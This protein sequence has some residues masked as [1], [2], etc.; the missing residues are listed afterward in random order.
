MAGLWVCLKISADEKKSSQPVTET[1]VNLF[2][3]SYLLP[4]RAPCSGCFLVGT[5]LHRLKR[6]RLEASTLKTSPAIQLKPEW[7]SRQWTA[8]RLRKEHVIPPVPHNFMFLRGSEWHS[9]LELLFLR[10]VSFLLRNS[11]D[12]P[13]CRHAPAVHLRSGATECMPYIIFFSYFLRVL[14]ASLLSLQTDVFLVILLG[15]SA[16]AIHEASKAASS[17][18]EQIC[19]RLGSYFYLPDLHPCARC[20]AAFSYA[21]TPH[22]QETHINLH[23]RDW[24]KKRSLSVLCSVL[25]NSFT[26]TAEMNLD[27]CRLSTQVTCVICSCSQTSVTS[28]LKNWPRTKKSNMLDIWSHFLVF[29][30]DLQ[31]SS[32]LIVY[33]WKLTTAHL[34]F[35]WEPP[36]K[37][38]KQL[39]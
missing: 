38:P 3:S 35:C 8:S 14:P 39:M 27:I 2:S 21:F 34:A 4:P 32:R 30:F 1:R 7:A 10:A 6:C 5:G 12:T 37:N 33:C 26:H 23:K 9:G 13:C 16:S 36:G 15:P 29:V 17:S 18:P 31:S 25:Q 28:A 19:Q 22:K 20:P 11:S 24:E